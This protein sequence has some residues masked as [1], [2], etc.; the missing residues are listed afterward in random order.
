MGFLIQA[1]AFTFVPVWGGGGVGAC[2][3]A[4]VPDIDFKDT[5]QFE[6]SF[7]ED[8]ILWKRLGN[9]PQYRNFVSAIVT[10]LGLH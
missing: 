4:R 8:E 6:W 9:F 5:D 1:A 2:V 10:A 7:L 3:R